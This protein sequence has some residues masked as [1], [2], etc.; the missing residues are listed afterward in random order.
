VLNVIFALASCLALAR[1]QQRFQT[2][3]SNAQG[4][5]IFCKSERRIAAHIFRL[6]ALIATSRATDAT[7]QA[8]LPAKIETLVIEGCAFAPDARWRE[9]AAA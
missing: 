1:D 7:G 5:E 4:P 6:F 2:A 3:R 8:P 9:C